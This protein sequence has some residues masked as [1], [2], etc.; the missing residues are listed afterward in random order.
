MDQALDCQINQA[1]EGKIDPSLHL[2]NQKE[3]LALYMSMNN[4]QAG[5]DTTPEER[6]GRGSS[7]CSVADPT[8]S[9]AHKSGNG[10]LYIR[11]QLFRG[12][13]IQFIGLKTFK[14]SFFGINV[15]FTYF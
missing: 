7:V 2:Y 10:S 14:S 6:S 12:M 8:L 1:T 4:D 11:I 13:R 3:P 9:S 5:P 15:K